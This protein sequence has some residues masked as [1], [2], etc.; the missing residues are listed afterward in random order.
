MLTASYGAGFRSP[1]A[2]SLADGQAAPF[3]RVHSGELGAR[4][5][6]E[7]V[8]RALAGFV[9]D[10]SRDLVFDHATG[11]QRGRARDS[12][13]RTPPPR[14]S[15]RWLDRF[16]SST[17]FTFTRASFRGSDER[18]LE[19]DLLPYAPQIVARSDLSYER[20]ITRVGERPLRGRVGTL[21]R[22]PGSSPAALLRDGS[23]R[24]PG[25]RE[26]QPPPQRSRR[27]A[28]RLQP[29]RHDSLRR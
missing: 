23:R 10:L 19:G 14:S 16:L 27:R 1:Q 17:S 8:T 9:L 18:Y 12:P 6:A 13:R 7:S 28:R 4:Y 20:D 29:A 11:P 5:A 26:R 22:L 21:P 15:A 25:R 24:L 3:A 2:R